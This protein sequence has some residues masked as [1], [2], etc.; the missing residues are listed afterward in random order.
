MAPIKKRG[1]PVFEV[2]EQHFDIVYQSAKKN[3]N[4]KQIAQALGIGIST[5][6]KNRKHFS[7]VLKKGKADS[8]EG[9]IDRV[10]NSLLKKCEGFWVE[11][12]ITERRGTLDK[13]NVFS[14]ST[15]AM[16]RKTKKYISPSDVAIFF[17]LVNKRPDLW[18][19]INRTEAP[20]EDDK[21]EILKA[22]KGMKSNVYT[23]PEQPPAEIENGETGSLVVDPAVW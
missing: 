18:K 4:E 21:G 19:S 17:F 22:I 12:T 6:I 14:G 1:R 7:E 20:S 2:N 5:F 8:L 9:L 3:L 13:D 11:E 15:Q 23:K 16:Q 10:E